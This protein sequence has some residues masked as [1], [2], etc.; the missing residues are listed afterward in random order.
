MIVKRIRA[1][2]GTTAGVVNRMGATFWGE[3]W[4]HA[5]W[6]APDY[7]RMD[8]GMVAAPFWT[9]QE[10]ERWVRARTAGPEKI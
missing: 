1:E 8:T 3:D 10:A 7:Q 5:G 9:A 2:D 4:R 6:L